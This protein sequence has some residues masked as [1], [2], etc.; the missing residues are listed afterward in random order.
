MDFSKLAPYEGG[1]A[2]LGVPTL[3]L[4]GAEDQF[5]PV[6]GAYR[7]KKQIP[8]AQLLAIEGAGHFVFDQEQERC[9]SAVADFLAANGGD[10]AEGG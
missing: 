2:R 8:G 1:L 10:P 5:A 7:F 4:W 9:A 3:L 6:G